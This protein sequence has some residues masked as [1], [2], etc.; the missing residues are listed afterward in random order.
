V[1]SPPSPEGSSGGGAAAGS[2]RLCGAPL[3][4]S[5][6]DD[7]IAFC[8]AGCARVHEILGGL[9]ERAGEA[10]LRAARALGLVPPLAPPAHPPPKAPPEPAAVR[11]ERFV[12]EGIFCP[13]C[14][15]VI[16]RVLAAQDGVLGADFDFFS[17]SGTVRFDLRRTSTDRLTEALAPFGYRL[18]RVED[19]ARGRISRGV[20]LAF[21]V[22]A[23]LT[24]NL[25]SLSVLRYA[26]TLGWLDELPSFLPVV[27]LLL[28]VPVLLFGWLP[29]ARRALV[30]LRR[31]AVTMDLLVST[32]VL[33]AFLL[34]AASLLLGREDLY[35]ETAAGLTTISLLSRMV[36]ARLRER[37][38][39]DVAA[40][41]RLGVARVRLDLPEDAAR[42]TTDPRAR[43][44][45]LEEVRPGDRLLFLG[46]ELVPFDGE[47]GEGEA[48][49]GE[50]VLTGEP[51]PVRKRRG[52]RIVAGS[53]VLEGALHLVASRSYRDTLLHRIAEALR[54]S[55]A[56]SEGRLRS[57]DRL[58][59]VFGPLV[60][61][62]ALGA[63]LV[64]LATHGL[65]FA[66][67]ADAW[68]PSVAV[69]AVACPCAFGLA[70][71][72]AVTSASGALLRRGLLVRDPAVLERLH[73]VETVVF[74][75][76]GTLTEGKM[77]VEAIV[78]R[79]DPRPELYETVLRAE[80]HAAHPVAEAIRGHLLGLEPLLAAAP[81]PPGDSVEDLPGRGRR[82]SSGGRVFSVGAASLFVDPFSPA[83]TAP[84]RTPVWF[85]WDGLAEGCFLLRDVLRPEAAGAVA[86]LRAAG[87]RVE[88]L[89][90]DRQEV[91]DEVALAVGADAARGEVS[92][93][94]KVRL[95]RD[96]EAR[97]ERL[98]L[99]GDG[100]N[101]AL[102]MS[103]AH[104]AVA[105]AGATDEAL[106]AAGLVLLHDRLSTLVGL[107]DLS[108]R[109]NRVV[110]G[111]YLW[112][113]GFNGLF[114]PVA[115]LGLLTPL[116]AMTLMLVS[117]SGVLLNSLRLS[118]DLGSRP[119]RA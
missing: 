44:R 66:L 12:A 78:W 71:V 67:G 32:S 81:G 22:C 33:A 91:C 54:G 85:G 77:S 16:E 4:E 61:L 11:E 35:F 90:G 29:S 76:T 58:A 93:E 23:V 48:H 96:R 98:A 63:W 88:V 116:A 26:R 69:L 113:F 42:G 104:A 100:T 65:P 86:G 50:A 118:R 114:L 94:E 83:R 68:F 107:F 55:L 47:V 101:D 73:E 28:C 19:P 52:D 56:A 2:C 45:P 97:G 80:A 62:L 39:R 109:L 105:I 40:V 92:L 18:S 119:P 82:L 59:G 111:N 38:L 1:T 25:M 5:A 108:R 43:Y 27:E 60:L 99:V 57:A 24:I 15:W 7:G 3:R 34:S 36:E 31:G 10:Y 74:D 64:R 102:A 53:T 95:V 84:R 70:G 49:L 87:L 9:D 110:R 112:A 72:A 14:T 6:P 13:S 37:A 8:C 75:K 17:G 30:A 21:L 89:S 103:A 106:A 46:G 51:A 41:M 20:T 117:S 115:A 79:G